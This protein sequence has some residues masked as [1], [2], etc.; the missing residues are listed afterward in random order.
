MSWN[1]KIDVA[2]QRTWR[3]WRPVIM[4]G[5]RWRYETGTKTG[6]VEVEIRTTDSGSAAHVCLPRPPLC[7][8][9][10]TEDEQLTAAKK[11]VTAWN[12]FAGAV[13][14]AQ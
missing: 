9:Y 6:G 14:R 11:I 7:P 2:W 5:Q 13:G 8:L 10:G 1:I 4:F 12:D 3:G